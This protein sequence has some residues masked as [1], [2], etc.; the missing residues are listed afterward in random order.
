MMYGIKINGTDTLTAYG[1]ALLSDLSVSAPELKENYVDV[2]GADGSL[3][4]SYALAG[5]PTYKDRDIA[6]TLFKR[7]D[8]FALSQIAQSISNAYHG[9]SVKIQ[10]P[11]DT[12]HYFTG[13]IQFGGADGYNSCK[14]PFSARVNPWRYKSSVTTVTRDDLTANYK[15]LTLT[16]ERRS[17]VPS[18]TVTEETTLLWGTATYTI[19]AGTYKLPDIVLTQGSNTLKAKLTTAASGSITIE[20]QEASL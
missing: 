9:R 1:L 18:I 3:N 12:D 17:V 13:V 10:T 8:D 20:Y 4:M 5:E 7:V 11:T 2:P 19:A 15:T 16:N 6:G 14:I